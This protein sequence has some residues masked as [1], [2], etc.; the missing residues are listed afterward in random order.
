LHSRPA[1]FCGRGHDRHSRQQ[2]YLS[3]LKTLSGERLKISP[4]FYNYDMVKIDGATF[5][6]TFLD[7]LAGGDTAVH[8][9]D[10]R[11]KVLVTILFTI[12][13]VSFGR[14]EVAALFPFFIFPA[15]MI[16]L[17]NLP[18]AF[19][20]RKIAFV[21]PFAMLVGILNPLFDREILVRVG[22]LAI[23]GG[24]VS[25]A[26]IVIRA[27]LTVAAAFILVMVTGFPAICAALERIGMPRAFAVQLLFLYRYIFVLIDEGKRVSRARDLR[28][29]GTR[30]RD[31]RSFGS[32]L[33][34]LLLRT[35]ERADR[36]HR[37]MLARGFT[38]EFHIRRTSRFGSGEAAFLLGWSVLFILFR[39]EN[40]P[41]ILGKFVTGLF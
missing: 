41:R 9:L 13:V 19:L 32:L 33:G 1:L 35:W 39:L 6:L 37:A 15:V 27:I 29:F 17:G 23:S 11:A 10:P 18:A 22:P 34:H 7:R 26:S 12:S 5:D 24:W 38:G 31:L 30:G 4:L 40:I 20:S 36:I 8:R 16:A 21:I 3:E 28:T 14:Y 2:G 25:F